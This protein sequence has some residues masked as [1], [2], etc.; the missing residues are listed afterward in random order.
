MEPQYL[1]PFSQGPTTTPRPYKEESSPHSR[2]MPTFLRF[3]SMLSFHLP[4]AHVSQAISS[5]R[6]SDYVL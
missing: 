1:L 2:A 3:V 4:Y 5:L 6:L